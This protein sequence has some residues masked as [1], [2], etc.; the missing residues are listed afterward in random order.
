LK[1]CHVRRSRLLERRFG[2]AAVRPRCPGLP[3]E[4]GLPARLRAGFDESPQLVA[5][6]IA[7]V[8]RDIG[9]EV[10]ASSEPNCR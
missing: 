3:L 9:G 2:A 1:L 7:A 5:V 6:E 10:G 4:L 8:Q